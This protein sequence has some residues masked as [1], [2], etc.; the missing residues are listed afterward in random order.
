M[1]HYTLIIW[2]QFYLKIDIKLILIL[3]IIQDEERLH[4]LQEGKEGR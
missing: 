2:F 3:Y 4:R 1:I